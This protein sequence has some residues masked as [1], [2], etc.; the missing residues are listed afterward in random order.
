MSRSPE[1]AGGA[2]TLHAAVDVNARESRVRTCFFE[3]RQWHK[4]TGRPY[5]IFFYKNTPPPPE[6]ATRKH[7]RKVIVN[8]TLELEYDAT[9]P[10]YRE[11]DYGTRYRCVRQ[12]K[13]D[14]RPAQVNV[15]VPDIFGP[16]D[17]TAVHDYILERFS[18]E[19][20]FG[21]PTIAGHD[22]PAQAI[23]FQ[24]DAIHQTG[25]ITQ[26][27]V[28]AVAGHLALDKYL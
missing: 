9:I 21:P 2:V 1:T 7:T 22:L 27:I 11:P 23:A 20:T 8:E 17:F 3:R 28:C 13:T 10:G 19:T 15:G 14:Y 18:Q 25:R 6:P 26:H 4:V 24:P 12:Q 5:S 16:T